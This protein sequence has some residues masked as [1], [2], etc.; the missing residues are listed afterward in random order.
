MRRISI[1]SPNHS[2]RTGEVRLIVLHT[3]EGARTIQELGHF[4]QNPAV[5]ASSHAGVDD[6]PDTIG[7]YVH[8]KDKAWA[9]VEFNSVSVNLEQC[10]FAAW[11]R[12]EWLQHPN[13]LANAAHW[14]RNQS[15]HYDIPMVALTPQQAQGSGRGVCQH[16]DLGAAGGGHSDCGPDYPMDH[17]LQ[18]ARNL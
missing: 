11:S 1:P 7:I 18:M 3:A 14:V 5:Q 6:T 8:T 4:F 15:K 17:V 10:A 2:E 13:M 9:C 16:R 12:D